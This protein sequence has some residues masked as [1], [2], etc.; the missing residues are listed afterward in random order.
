MAR[1]LIKCNDTWNDYVMPY[2]TSLK[3]LVS[4]AAKV[5]TKK[6]RKRSSFH[7]LHTVIQRLRNPYNKLGLN[8]QMQ[9][10]PFV[11]S[12]LPTI[13]MLPYLLFTV[14]GQTTLSLCYFMSIRMHFNFGITNKNLNLVVGKRGIHFTDIQTKYQG[15]RNNE[16][17]ALLSL[18]FRTSTLFHKCC[19]VL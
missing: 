4:E 9:L 12:T 5:S 10:N 8:T 19:T 16:Y 13:F 14:D 17:F 15:N 18:S 7:L 11:F 6:K 1:L 3:D 2:H